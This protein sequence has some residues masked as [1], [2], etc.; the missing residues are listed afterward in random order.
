MNKTSGRE[1]TLIALAAVAV[2]GAVVWTV[3]GWNARATLA[4]T[5]FYF[6]FLLCLCGELLRTRSASGQAMTTMAATPHIASMLVMP[7]PE[8]MAVIG[9]SSIVSGRLIHK[10]SWAHSAY[11]AGAVTCV[12]GL[13][14]L[15]FDTLAKDGWKPTALVASGY[16]VP[17]LTAALVYFATYY[18]AQVVWT[19]LEE[20]RTPWSVTREQFGSSF[21]FLAAGALLS[22]GM[23]LA[24]QFRLAGAIGAIAVVIPVVVAK[25]GFDQFVVV[26]RHRGEVSRRDIGT[27]RERERIPI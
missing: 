19:S 6:W 26:G 7:R 11:D 24:V 27:T 13:S 17:I 1:I 3:W 12:I 5:N 10:R 20:G 25:Y 14:R 2:V 16:Y 21:D 8:A 15:V 18:A 22:L 4:G 23:L 9:L